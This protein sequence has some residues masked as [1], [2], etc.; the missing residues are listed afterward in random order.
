M[1]YPIHEDRSHQRGYNL[2]QFKEGDQWKTA[3]RTRYGHF[4]YLVI[5][6]SLSNAPE[7][8]QNMMQEIFRDLSDHGVVIY[9][10][11]ILIDSSTR[12]QHADLIREVL[13]RLREW[14][15]ATALEK[16]EWSR[17]TVEFLGYIASKE[18]VGMTE[19]KVES[20][21][22]EIPQIASVTTRD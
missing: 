7:S 8:F 12:G 3:F 22:H 20:T 9:I 4:E 10:N 5:P 18:G 21:W 15:R 17:S 11:D 16:Y 13:R 1:S 6:F 14:N 2:I 19:E